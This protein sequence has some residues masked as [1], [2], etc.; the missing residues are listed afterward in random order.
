MEAIFLTTIRTEE[1]PKEE[2]AKKE[3]ETNEKE[4]SLNIFSLPIGV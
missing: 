1:E 2:I 3:T 4:E